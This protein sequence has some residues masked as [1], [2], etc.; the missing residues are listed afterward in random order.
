MP[1]LGLVL[2]LVLCGS[3]ASA[4]PVPG[5]QPGVLHVDLATMS[6]IRFLGVVTLNDQRVMHLVIDHA[7]LK[8]VRVE[9]APL[10]VAADEV[11][12]AGPQVSVYATRI[13]LRI[14]GIPVTFTPM[15]NL[16]KI[17]GTLPGLTVTDATLEFLRVEP[18]GGGQVTLDSPGL[19]LTSTQ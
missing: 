2:A 18:L 15:V 11:T 14:A 17:P 10:N 13:G 5:Q 4:A 16:P 3:V 12:V 1:L 9:C 6:R 7:V 8:G 19:R